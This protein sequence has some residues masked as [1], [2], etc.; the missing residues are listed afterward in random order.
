MQ[1]RKLRNKWI[2][3]LLL[4]LYASVFAKG[5][6]GLDDSHV[7]DMLKVLGLFTDKSDPISYNNF[8]TLNPLFFTYNHFY[9]DTLNVKGIEGVS[10]SFYNEIQKNF[11]F[12]YDAEKTHRELYHW[13]FDFD[14]DL[15]IE[16][17]PTDNQIPEALNKT[18][19]KWNSDEAVSDWYR[20][21]KF[22][23]DEQ[24]KRND[25]F[26][27]SLNSAL[28]LRSYFDARDIAAVLYYTH[29]LG[30]HFEHSGTDSANGILELNK[31]EKN[32]ALHIKSLSKKCDWYYSDYE[33][34]VK[35][36]ISRNDRERA[37][38]VLNCLYATIPKILE[39]KYSAEFAA[40]NLIFCYESYD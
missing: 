23:R 16:G 1:K 3:L 10:D 31:I 39:Y 9:I 29:I 37:Q 20:F 35:S 7:I 32:L 11:S 24:A 21:L 25:S 15:T 40:K 13:G 4:F 22:L 6:V 2:P 30:D 5:S 34:S 33:Q 8:N 12:K 28:G 17:I 26:I 14:T 18:F 36:I 27:R 19:I 38:E